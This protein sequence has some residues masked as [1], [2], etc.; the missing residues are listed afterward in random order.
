MGCSGRGPLHVPGQDYSLLPPHPST[1]Q[2]VTAV[3]SF[4]VEM[5]ATAVAPPP[6]TN[7][8]VGFL[9]ANGD[10]RPWQVQTSTNLH[11]GPWLTVQNA[12]DRFWWFP[13]RAEPQRYFR[14]VRP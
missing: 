1:A 14:L 7:K 5:M 10:T 8:P 11:G 3:E 12:S 6:E 13:D 2:S 4:E 9:I